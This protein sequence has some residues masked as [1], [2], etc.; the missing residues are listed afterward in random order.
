MWNPK[1]IFRI[2]NSARQIFLGCILSVSLGGCA[3]WPRQWGDRPCCIQHKPVVRRQPIWWH[4]FDMTVLDPLEQPLRLVRPVRKW[5][6]VP[7]RSLNLHHGE[8]GDSVF[9]TNRDP[10]AS[11]PET[12]R[13][14]PTTPEDLA[15]A[16]FTVTKA[17]TEGKTPGFFVTDGRGIRYLFKLDPVE[18]P[19]LL[20]GAEVVTSKLLYTLGYH[21]PS[22]EIVRV[23]RDQL[24]A[25]SD[26]VSR[27]G[28]STAP[29]RE[30]DLQVLLAG[31]LR[32]G[33]VRVAASKI[34][35]GE[36]LGPARFKRFR[37]CTDVRALK[38]AYAWVNNI[39][40]KDHNSLLTWDG[41]K[42]V[43][44]LFDFGTSLG[45]DAGLAGPKTS[46][47]G[48]TYLFDLGEGFLKLATLGLHRT[49]CDATTRP[50]DASVGLFSPHVDPDHWKPYAPNRAF[51]EMNADDARWIARRMA[52]LSRPQIEA[53]VSAG[54][55]SNPADAAYL[56]DTLEAR[57]WAIVHHY[58]GE[59]K[60]Q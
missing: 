60:K 20:S 6:G 10:G 31:R 54:E 13:W 44:Y 35:E 5:L 27:A 38:V 49:T 4:L 1:R 39:D 52:R 2:P 11:S 59:G 25:A 28:R 8:V 23:P 45:A 37:D 22:Y 56:V 43:G 32:D 34:V 24:R 14:G 51:K 26:A 33:A 42:T 19:E 7:V 41:T 55:Y 53:A 17:K 3:A 15:V 21:V 9:F 46:C 40:T 16:P 18:E 30:S 58:L 57:R 36:I 29:F 12:V 48:W 47:A 50:V